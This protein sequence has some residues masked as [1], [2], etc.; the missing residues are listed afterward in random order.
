MARD[1]PARDLVAVDVIDD[2]R[3]V[4]V[5]AT[6]E[7]HFTLDAGDSWRRAEVATDTILRRVSM[8]D[9]THGWVAGDGLILRTEDGGAHWSSQRIPGRAS[10]TRFVGLAAIDANRAIAV[11]DDGLRLRTIDG[12]QSWKEIVRSGE[13]E[14]GSE[15]GGVSCRADGSGRCGSIG[16]MIRLTED[17]GE[18]W[19]PAEIESPVAFEPVRFEAGRVELSKGEAERLIE[20]AGSLQARH[21]LQWRIEAGASAREIDRIVHQRDPMASLELI[22]ARAQEV[23]SLIEEAGVAPQSIS[24]QGVPPW[25]YED[26][27]DDDPEFLERYWTA[28]TFPE[29]SVRITVADAPRV[30]AIDISETG[31]GVAVGRDGVVLRSQD[32]GRHW[33]LAEPF[34][35]HDLLDLG[36]GDRRQVIVGAQG[37]LWLSDDGG[38][39]WSR[40]DP[41]QLTPFFETLRSVDFS[42]S[43][44]LGLIVGEDGHILRS[45]DGGADWAPIPADRS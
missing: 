37:G 26:Y 19:V 42:E 24:L 35:S 28:R 44:H 6:G 23:L 32:G 36:F 16:E 39:S 10:K 12:G 21:D 43:G 25:D 17:G 41:E 5:A 15:F 45:V 2:Q 11:G 40:P 34:S 18:T 29:P 22:D 1:W 4:V 7:I 31:I 3:A 30:A 13:P 14:I 9:A 20:F 38:R 8:A 33:Q 27:L